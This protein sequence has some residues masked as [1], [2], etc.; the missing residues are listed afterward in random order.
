[1]AADR[2]PTKR[3]EPPVNGTRYDGTGYTAIVAQV[4]R[5]YGS[6]GRSLV[7]CVMY[8][9]GTREDIQTNAGRLASTL[10]RVEARGLRRC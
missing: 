5:A 1:M 10:R 2:R 4:G 3:K 8:A 9:D 7:L 6:A